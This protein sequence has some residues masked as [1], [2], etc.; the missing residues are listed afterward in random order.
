[1]QIP[2]LPLIRTRAQCLAAPTR[3][4]GP[5][6]ALYDL[7]QIPDALRADLPVVPP[8][9]QRPPYDLA[10]V[11]VALNATEMPSATRRQMKDALL[12]F[13]AADPAEPQP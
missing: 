3:R 8:A 6:E 2:V 9:N 4:L 7:A 10:A 13:A 5:V 1:M 11:F 12:F